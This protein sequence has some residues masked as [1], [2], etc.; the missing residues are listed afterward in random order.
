MR[1]TFQPGSGASDARPE[2]P[3]L[4]HL[5]LLAG[6]AGG[7]TG[8]LPAEA[9]A[10]GVSGRP[11]LFLHPLAIKQ[12]EV[13]QANLW[14]RYP[15][16]MTT[17]TLFIGASAGCG[18]STVVD[19][20]VAALGRN[21][22]TRVLLIEFGRAE[23]K[24]P[25]ADEHGPDLLRLLEHVQP[26]HARPD[27]LLDL[28]GVGS[29]NLSMGRMPLTTVQSDAFEQFLQ[30]ARSRFDHVVIDA[31][32]LQDHAE[33]LVLSRKADGV[34]LVVDSGRTRKQT[35][36]WTKQQIEEAG[37]NLLGVVLNRRKYYIPRWLYSRV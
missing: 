12:C 37:G 16:D 27:N 29:L 35:A 33:S 17:V 22:A 6:G 9:R 23:A 18:V 19:N 13:L 5:D 31:P 1:R 21:A 25:T 8:P 28:P 32:P 24:E 14:L 4:P 11:G 20:F 3:R 30:V 7:R 34:I 2:A 36:L 26:P 15:A 10:S